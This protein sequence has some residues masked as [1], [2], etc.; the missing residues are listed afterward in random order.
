[1]AGCPA[2]AAVAKLELANKRMWRKNLRGK[3]EFR[4]ETWEKD[5]GKLDPRTTLQIHGSNP[6]KSHQNQQITKN[7]VRLFLVGIFELGQKQTKLG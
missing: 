4:G 5:G 3:G 6:T 2:P 7:L 1:M